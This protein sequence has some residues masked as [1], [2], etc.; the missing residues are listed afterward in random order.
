METVKNISEQ[1]A[2]ETAKKIALENDWVWSEP[3]EAVW[4][5]AWRGGGGK[6]EIFSNVLKLGAKV[7]LVIESPSGKILEKGYIPR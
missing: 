6:W 4:H 7:R 1:E 2:I 5:P 3:T